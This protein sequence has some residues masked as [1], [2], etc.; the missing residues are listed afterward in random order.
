MIMTIRTHPDPVLRQ[1]AEPVASLDDSIKKL[2]QDMF[3]TM[4]AAPGVGLAA[5]Q[6]GVS[7]RVIVIDLMP[8]GVR[9]DEDKKHFEELKE[10]GYNGPIA[11]VNPVIV[12]REGL[13]EWEEGCLSV[14][15]IAVEVERSERVL[16]KG[17]DRQGQE[18]MIEGHE[19]FAVALQHEIDHL[20]GRLMIDY[21]PKKQQASV[22]RKLRERKAKLA[23]AEST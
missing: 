14:P 11:L 15:E 8:D 13:F 10:L 4:Y 12:E 19:Y 1:L 2:I 20:D 17:L 9:N 5:P 23:Q 22:T 16:V 6:V 18:V 21:L 7:L 3:E